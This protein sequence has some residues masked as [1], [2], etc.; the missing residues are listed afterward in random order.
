MKSD[1][2]EGLG[3][4]DPTAGD[5]A[6][7]DHTPIRFTLKEHGDGEPWVMLEEEEPGLPVL[8]FGDAFLG[9]S[10]RPEIPFAEAEKFA[11]EMERM[12]DTLS[13]TKFDT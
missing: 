5:R 10:F 4:N 12:F 6:H 3:P 11:H 8:K 7:T 2:P 9:L 13:Y 1:Y